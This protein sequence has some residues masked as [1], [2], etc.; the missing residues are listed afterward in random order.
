MLESKDNY[1]I[2]TNLSDIFDEFYI[3][4]QQSGQMDTTVYEIMGRYIQMYHREECIERLD[5]N[6]FDNFYRNFLQHHIIEIDMNQLHWLAK[7]WMEFCKY[8]NMLFGRTGSVSAAKNAYK[9]HR[10]ELERLLIN[11]HQIRKHS[12]N[13]VIR[14]KP[15]IVDFDCYKNKV[16]REQYS[17]QYYVFEQGYFSVNDII[18]YFVILKKSKPY[19]GLFKIKIDAQL[20]TNMRPGDILHMSIKR[21]M[22]CTTWDIVHVK[23]YYNELAAAQLN[24][25]G[26]KNESRE[27]FRNL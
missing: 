3:H 9:D 12:E 15:F 1:S 25:G 13:P 19:P 18:K 17:Y 7:E 23:A 26:N 21:K 22:F 24:I 5:S 10:A 2:S 27:N 8:T 4:R 14:W 11:L 20:A 16:S 6:F